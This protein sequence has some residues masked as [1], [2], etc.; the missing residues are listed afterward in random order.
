M[1]EL[2]ALV[3]QVPEEILD[4]IEDLETRVEKAEAV[5]APE[6]E[7]DDLAGLPE[8]FVSRLKKA[9]QALEEERIAKADNE[10]IAKARKFD[11]LVDDPE[12]FGRKM[13]AVAEIDSELADGIAATLTAASAN[14]SKSDLFKE[15]GHGTPSAGSVEEKIA[16]IA[17]S[18]VEADPSK[19]KEVAEAEAW[20]ANPELYAEHVAERNAALR[21]GN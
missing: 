10:W 16:N 1:D 6:E 3:A 18:L 9:E 14:V 7:G 5:Q 11:G 21:G 2:E 19:S 20:E 4:Y 8:E 15:M 12:D 17:K 13:R